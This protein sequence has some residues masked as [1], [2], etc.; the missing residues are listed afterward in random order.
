M[1]KA[2]F[3]AAV[4]FCLFLLLAAAWLFYK[5]FIYVPSVESFQDAKMAMEQYVVYDHR[6][7][8][9]CG[10]EFDADKRVLPLPGFYTEKYKNRA[11]RVEWEHAVPVENF[12]RAFTAWNDG[13]E[14]CVRKDGKTYRGRKCAS[15][16]SAPFRKMEADMYNLFP[17]IG[18]VN[19]ARGIRAYSELGDVPAAF[20]SCDAKI[21][22]N[23]F[24]PPNHA[25]GQLAR[26]SLYMEEE[27]REATGGRFR[28][29]R[30]QRQLFKAWD[31]QYPV[32]DWECQRAR[33]IERIQKNENRFVKEPCIAAGLW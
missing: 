24:E 19:A 18:S 27:Y 8:I 5:I 17:S 31:R 2:L 1:K 3:S 23:R 7:T 14:Y 12:G 33:R 13:N 11:Q 22:E 28:L 20:G 21:A 29:S 32:D 30:Q 10:A 26:A 15:E 16:T 9:Y 4:I 6:Y 25:K